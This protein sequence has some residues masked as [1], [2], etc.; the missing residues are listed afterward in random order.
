[1]RL[2]E[3]DC[4]EDGSNALFVVRARCEDIAVREARHRFERD[5]P[6]PHDTIDLGS[7]RLA[8]HENG[9]SF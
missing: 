5:K 2:Y 7:C 8:V 9:R 3:F 1:M 6:H 4:K